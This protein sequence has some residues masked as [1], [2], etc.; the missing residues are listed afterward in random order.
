M[1]GYIFGMLVL[2]KGMNKTPN[3]FPYQILNFSN[4]SHLSCKVLNKNNHVNGSSRP[5]PLSMTTLLE[6]AI[7]MTRQKL[8]TNLDRVRDRLLLWVPLLLPD[9]YSPFH[10]CF[11]FLPP[12]LSLWVLV[13]EARDWFGKW[14]LRCMEININSGL[15][16]P[17]AV[18]SS[19]QIKESNWEGCG[20]KSKDLMLIQIQNFQ[21]SIS[22][23]SK[24]KRQNMKIAMKR[25]YDK[26]TYS[27]N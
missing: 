27:K 16:I 2:K 25:V 18:K 7:D 15:K 23:S 3:C 20:R 1:A 17:Q 13:C 5:N 22:N 9:P 6:V 11:P 19:T 24:K 12:K 14:E 10:S 26:S 8:H 4:S 21:S